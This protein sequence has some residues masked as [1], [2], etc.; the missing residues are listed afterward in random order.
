MARKLTAIEKFVRA[1]HPYHDI[2]PGRATEQRKTL[3]AFEAHAGVPI[4]QADDAHLRAFL[5]KLVADG[6]HVNT[7]R[8]KR[9][10]IVPFYGWCFDERLVSAEVLMRV[11]RVKPPR[12]ATGDSLPRPYKRTEIRLFWADLD[13]SWPRVPDER[14]RRWREGR[15]RYRRVSNHCMN[16]QINAVAHLALH[17]GLRRDEIFRAGL[18]DIHYDNAY[19]VVRHGAR[20]N[21]QGQPKAREVPMTVGLEGA[22]REW[23]DL[24]EVILAQA[25]LERRHE[26]PWLSLA[27]NQP[28]DEWVKP[29]RHDRFAELLATVGEGYMLHRL[30]HTCG[31]EWLRSGLPLE[32]VKELLGHGRLQQTLAYAEI[33]AT[34]LEKGMGGVAVDFQMAVGRPVFEGKEVQVQVEEGEVAA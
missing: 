32:Q 5:A 19:V 33:L 6:L 27:S 1:Y 7:V 22:L 8:K 16:A 17:A 34:D 23:F 9:G 30:R 20:K 25:P 13:A 28:K 10:M 14:L 2:S 4:E 29:M 24:R 18:K 3:L 26:S 12:G 15:A 31:T 21:P 11:T